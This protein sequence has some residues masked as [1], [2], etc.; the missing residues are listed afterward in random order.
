MSGPDSSSNK[1]VDTRTSGA[2]DIPPPPEKPEPIEC[3]GSGCV[4]CISDYYYDRL[5]AWEAKYGPLEN[6]LAAQN[7]FNANK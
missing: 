6:Y 7:N 4:P 2:R 1:Q 3:C 5:D